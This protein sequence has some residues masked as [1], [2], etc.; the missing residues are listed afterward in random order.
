MREKK[1]QH[2]A[3]SIDVPLWKQDICRQLFLCTDRRRRTD[4][5]G[6]IRLVVRKAEINQPDMIAGVGNQDIGGLQ[7]TVD[8]LAVM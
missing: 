7:I 2:L 4:I 3:Q 5:L 1:S 8:Y 6:D